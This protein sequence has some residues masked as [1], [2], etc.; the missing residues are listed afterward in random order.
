MG[1]EAKCRAFLDG[2]GVSGRA[3]LETEELIFRGPP[4]VRAV[5]RFGELSKVSA[6]AGSLILVSKGGARAELE[7]G[8]RAAKWAEKIRSPKGRLEKLG[9]TG[10]SVVALSGAPLEDGFLAELDARAKSVSG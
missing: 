4:G 1:N 6:E 10:D 8:E 3:L 2:K 7:L 9:V 5:F